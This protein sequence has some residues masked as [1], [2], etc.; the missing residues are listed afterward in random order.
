MYSFSE[1]TIYSTYRFDGGAIGN[2]ALS[3]PK[4]AETR[5]SNSLLLADFLGVVS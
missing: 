4:M 3:P 1:G 5:V 2:G